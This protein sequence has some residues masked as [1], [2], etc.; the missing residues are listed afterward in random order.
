MPDEPPLA[1]SLSQKLA[2]GNLNVSIDIDVVKS[3]WLGSGS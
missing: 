2:P 1:A 3:D